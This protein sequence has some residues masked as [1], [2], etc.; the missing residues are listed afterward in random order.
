M[1][2]F[3]EQDTEA[4]KLGAVNFYDELIVRRGS[5]D[6]S[7]RSWHFARYYFNAQNLEVA[8]FIPDLLPYHEKNH[9]NVHPQPRKWGILN[10]L[11]PIKGGFY[12]YVKKT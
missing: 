3:E 5:Y 9:L 4:L 10:R 7:P 1:S 2:Q 12:D 6:I 11:E 8:Y